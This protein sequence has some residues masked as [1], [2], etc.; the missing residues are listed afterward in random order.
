MNP[1]L[2]LLLATLL[3]LLTSCS[4]VTKT[5]AVPTGSA[6]SAKPSASVINKYPII[7][8][9]EQLK[10]TP[11]HYGGV[12]PNGFDC[13]G[14]VYYSY[15]QIGKQIPRTTREQYQKSKLLPMTQARPGDLLFFSISSRTLEHVGL[16]TG[17]GRFLHASKSKQ[18]ITDA[19][20]LNPYWRNRLLAV[21]RISD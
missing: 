3:W 11:Y 21:G 18:R 6:K 13:S 16:Y 2:T 20:L 12:S 8:V 1:I 17:E 19:S 9:A 10:G 14:F 4:S 15:Q 7:Q 5:S